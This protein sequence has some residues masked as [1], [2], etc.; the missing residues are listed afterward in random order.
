MRT[1]QLSS[2]II[3]RFLKGMKEYENV[4]SLNNRKPESR[5]LVQ[6]YGPKV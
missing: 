2:S 1:K 4:A 6:G 3:L 5:E